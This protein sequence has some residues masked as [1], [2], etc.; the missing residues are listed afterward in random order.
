MLCYGS[1]GSYECDF[2]RRSSATFE[3]DGGKISATLEISITFQAARIQRGAYRSK[4]LISAD[5][6]KALEKVEAATVI[7]VSD[8]IGFLLPTPST[9][10]WCSLA[11]ARFD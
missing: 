1:Y 11:V 10:D 2:G 9:R 7:S 8:R 3:S 6:K 5:S 4:D